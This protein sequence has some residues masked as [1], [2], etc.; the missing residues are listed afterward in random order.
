MTV[1]ETM[2]TENGSAQVSVITNVMIAIDAATILEKYTPSTDP[3]NPTPVDAKYIYMTTKQDK[4]VGSPGG[5]LKFRAHVGDV[6]RWRESTFSLNFDYSALLYEYRSQDQLL[7]TPAP[8]V[9]E[10][11]FPYPTPKQPGD[12]S[13][14]QQKVKTHYWQA[15]VQQTGNVTYTFC[16]QLLDR[17]KLMGYFSWDPYIVIDEG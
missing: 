17:G 16:F 15:T 2:A 9:S 10:S 3:K 12:P 7:S 14:A 8:L 5:E 4:V 1:L 6:I 11:V 13:F